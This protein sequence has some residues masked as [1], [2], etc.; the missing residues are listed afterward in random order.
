MAPRKRS[1]VW[2]FFR[3]VDEK[4]VT[5]L[6]CLET[7][8]HCGH[9]TN[10]LRHLRSKHLN[11]YSSAA[12]SKDRRSVAADNSQPMMINSEDYCDVEVALEEQ[13]P[14][15]AASVSDADIATAINGI[16]KAA[17]DHAVGR[18]SRAGIVGQ[19]SAGATP[20]GRKWS[21]VWTH[22]ERLEEQNRA[23]CLICN[24]KIQH[25]SSTS[26]LL[27]HLSK[28][29][30]DAFARL[31]CHIKKQKT[32]GVQKT[33][34]RDADSGPKHTNLSRRIGEVALKQSP[35]KFPDAF[36][37][38]GAC[39][40]EVR[41]LERER[42]LTEA[43]RSAQQ[44]EARALEQQRELLETLRRA[45]TRETSAEKEALETL[46]RSQKQEARSLQ[47]ERE[48]LQRERVE[49]QLEK[50][51]MQRE[52]EE[53][54]CLRREYGQDRSPVQTVDRTTGLFQGDVEQEVTMREEVL[55]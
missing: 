52:R 10:M 21:S 16:L 55:G 31:E 26:N 45:N 19:G 47:R 2:S 13:P 7:V 42:E 22:Y 36:D 27:R 38:M 53:L 54:E 37:M 1:V 32:S 29:H 20:S 14:E 51:R 6:L 28:R 33:L 17:E 40:R 30:P 34:R 12:A 23:L 9:T 3:A 46:R 18:E 39:E 49:L 5:C 50:E 35:G 15:Q 4:K 25:Q 8:L 48:D 41:V 44:Q 24:E 11:E 43:L